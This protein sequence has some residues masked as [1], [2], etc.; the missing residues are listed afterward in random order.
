M[1][2]APRITFMSKAFGL[3]GGFY[4]VREVDRRPVSPEFNHTIG[5]AESASPSSNFT[6]APCLNITDMG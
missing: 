1:A 5:G 6:L 4:G 2:R 3:Q